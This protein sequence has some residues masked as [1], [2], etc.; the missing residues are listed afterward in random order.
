MGAAVEVVDLHKRYDV[1]PV[2]A[3]ISFSVGAGTVYCLLGRNGAGKTTTVECIEGFRRPDRGAIR[4]LGLDPV[5]DRARLAPDVGVMLQEGG[6]YQAASPR[7][8]LQLYARLYPRAWAVEELLALT[9][10]AQLADRR[11]RTLSGGEKQ[12]V[13]LALALAGRPQV[14]FLDEPTAGMDPA[15]RRDVWALVERLRDEGAAVLLT[16]HLLDEVERL[17]DRVGILADGAIVAE[18]SPGAL[19]GAASGVVLQTTDDLD[20]AALAAAIHAPVQR[21]AGGRYFV[22]APP[23]RIGAITAWLAE[24]DLPL[25]GVTPARRS[26]DDVFVELTGGHP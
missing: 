2:L 6:A 23:D 14:L 1:R 7:E 10:L 17:A 15:T 25:H 24:Q 20:V 4:V 19:T 26:L 3:G 16:T 5:A 8:M 22:A 9:G 11:L 21:T 13:N 18:D 12:R